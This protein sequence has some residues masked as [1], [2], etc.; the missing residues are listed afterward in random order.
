MSQFDCDPYGDCFA[1]FN[2]FFYRKLKE[3]ARPIAD[4]DDDHVLVSPADCRLTVFPSVND[5]TQIWIKGRNFSLQ[6][7]LVHPELVNEWKDCTLAIARLAPQ[8]YHRFHMPCSGIVERHIHYNGDYLSVNP[9]A[10]RSKMDVLDVNKRTCTVLN[11]CWGDDVL[12]IAVGA[13]LVGSIELT[14]Q[15]G[16]IVTKGDEH[17]YFAFGGSTVILL[18]KKNTVIFSRDLW[19]N[20]QN[21]LETLVKMGDSI[22]KVVETD[23]AK[24][25]KYHQALRVLKEK[26]SN[27]LNCNIV[28]QPESQSEKET[29]KSSNKKNS[30]R[31]VATAKSSDKSNEKNI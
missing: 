13:A 25:Q 9:L 24:M 7:L 18:F 3:G 2:D 21:A 26:Q 5:A 10:I 20:S 28:D 8:D 1:T 23:S 6:S 19:R 31:V 12:L 17:G 22:G 29:R 14:A 27:N 4:A 30:K 16:Q 15:A 11:S